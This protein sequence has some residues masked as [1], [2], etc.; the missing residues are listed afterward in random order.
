MECPTQKNPH[1]IP[2]NL[3]LWAAFT[4]TLSHEVAMASGV[5]YDNCP[6]FRHEV[7]MPH[8]YFRNVP[9]SVETGKVT[10]VNFTYH[11]DRIKFVDED[12]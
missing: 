10:V 8:S 2:M 4:F 11:I 1:P 3:I 7:V 5:A 6:G 9:D 12:K